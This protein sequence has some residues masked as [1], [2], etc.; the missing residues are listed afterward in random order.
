MAGPLTDFAWAWDWQCM[1]RNGVC[2]RLNNRLGTVIQAVPARITS[3]RK[4]KPDCLELIALPLALLSEGTKQ[5]LEHT[6][7]PKC[8]R[9]LAAF[10]DPIH[11]KRSS[12]PK[13]KHVFRIRE[14]PAFVLCSAQFRHAVQDLKLENIDFAPIAV[15][16]E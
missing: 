7:C 2:D 1:L 5:S 8:F 6:D 14:L 13:A 10:D 15:A 9:Y 11:V 12:L 3:R 16:M 4:E